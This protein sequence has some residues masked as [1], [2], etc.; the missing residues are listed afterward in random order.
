MGII[1]VVYGHA[2]RGQV[3]SGAFDPA[4]HADLQDAVIYAF[5]MPLF[6]FLAGLFVQ[7]SIAKG[8]SAFLR[9][10]VLTLV[11]PYF[12]WSIISI[13]FGL[14]ATGSVNHQIDASAFIM[15]WRDPVYQYWFLY[16]LLLCQMVTLITRADWRVNVLLCGAS[17]SGIWFAGVGM[18]SL[19]LTYYLYFGIGV[20]V[21]PFLL[22]WQPRRATL[23]LTALGSA[24]IFGMSYAVDPDLPDRVL[25]LS[26]AVTGIMM[27][28]AL[29]MMLGQS[30]PWLSVLGQASMAIYVLH[31]IFSAG[32]RIGARQTGFSDNLLLLAAGTLVGIIAPY[33]MWRIAGR[34]HIVPLLGL[35]AQPRY[36]TE[37]G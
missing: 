10:K 33:L 4:W 26:R 6:F 18:V 24:V 19:T 29:A 14:L 9:D 34:Y 36:R 37:R 32:L 13:A 22:A 35:G 5:H 2:L 12:L 15:L 16:A 11:Y 8:A 31:T 7:R 23:L 20:L 3:T 17:A 1:L 25:V 21:A 30:V 28:V 27:L